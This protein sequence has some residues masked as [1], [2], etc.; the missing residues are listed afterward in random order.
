V[1]LPVPQEECRLRIK[2]AIE[3]N[4]TTIGM[5]AGLLA[6][7]LFVIMYF[8]WVHQSNMRSGGEDSEPY[9]GDE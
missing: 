3:A 2:I 6:V 9:E 5:I 4:L 8:T 1:Y 7:G